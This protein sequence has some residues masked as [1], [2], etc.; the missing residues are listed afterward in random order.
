MEKKVF[1]FLLLTMVLA[2]TNLLSFK[3]K[4]VNTLPDKEVEIRVNFYG[5]TKFITLCDNLRF[6]LQPWETKEFDKGLCRIASVAGAIYPGKPGSSKDPKRFTQEIE[7]LIKGQSGDAN[8]A[9]KIKTDGVG[10]TRVYVERMVGSD[11]LADGWKEVKDFL[12]P[13]QT[14]PAHVQREIER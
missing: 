11:I 14:I 12:T 13:K 10:A 1:S 7:P 5:N 6:V 8:Y 4:F 3:Y 9:V 2:S